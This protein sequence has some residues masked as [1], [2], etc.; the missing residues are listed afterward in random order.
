MARRESDVR[1]LRVELRQRRF[2]SAKLLHAGDDG[3]VG[4]LAVVIEIHESGLAVRVFEIRFRARH[5][6]RH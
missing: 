4:A 1:E 3:R 5:A 6:T 2:E